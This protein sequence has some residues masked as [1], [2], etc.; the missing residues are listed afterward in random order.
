MEPKVCGIFFQAVV[1]AVMLYGSETWVV[2]EVEMHRLEGFYYRE[3]CKMARE[4]QPKNNRQRGKWKYPEKTDVFTE[5]GV[6]PS[7][8]IST[9]GGN[10]SGNISTGTS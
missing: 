5:V 3:T 1:Q 7:R 10:P 8:N 6:G 9:G 2:S 4:N